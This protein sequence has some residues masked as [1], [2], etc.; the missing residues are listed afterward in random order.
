MRTLDGPR[1]FGI[2]PRSVRI[3]DRPGAYAVIRDGRGR[4]AVVLGRSGYHL[5]GGGLEADESAVEALRR[6][7]IEEIG[8]ELSIGDHIGDARQY[9]RAST[10]RCYNKICAYF[11]AWIRPDVPPAPFAEHDI[12]WLP[13]AEAVESLDHD[14]HAWAVRRALGEG[15]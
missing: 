15:Y 9:V 8:F 5:P 2:R 14:S 11:R 6:E 1:Q 4:V 3:H 12:V 7:G 13:P 10:G